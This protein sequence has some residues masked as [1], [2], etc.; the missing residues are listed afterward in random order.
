M[1][2]TGTNAI[3]AVI[4]VCSSPII[5]FFFIL[6]MK[7]SERAKQMRFRRVITKTASEFD[8]KFFEDWLVPE[9]IAQRFDLLKIG[10]KAVLENVIE[11]R[12]GSQAKCVI[13]VFRYGR[14]SA[15]GS[16]DTF[17]QTV[18]LFI[19]ESGLRQGEHE[20]FSLKR[21]RPFLFLQLSDPAGRFSE[22]V[23]R[24]ISKRN[25]D[26]EVADSSLLLY[27]H[28]RRVSADEYRELLHD[29]EVVWETTEASLPEGQ[30][31]DRSN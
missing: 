12:Q 6:W 23:I 7:K 13:G 20:H 18:I 15:E 1:K 31:E 28:E 29:A 10:K 4:V 21:K 9:E 26:V 30:N 5:M 17:E 19:D 25:W 14:V 24:I 11:I 27:Q 8:G 22:K 2:L 3:L 16:L